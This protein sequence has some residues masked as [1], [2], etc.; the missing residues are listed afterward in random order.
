M[1]HGD[2]EGEESVEVRLQFRAAGGDGVLAA[3]AGALLELKDGFV[4]FECY[5]KL[6]VEYK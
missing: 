5:K 3:A 4:S 1:W 2:S 6:F